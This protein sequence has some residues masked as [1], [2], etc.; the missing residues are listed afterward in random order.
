M[1]ASVSAVSQCQSSGQARVANQSSRES[2]GIRAWILA[3]SLV[4]SV[5][6]SCGLDHHTHTDTRAVVIGSRRNSRIYGRLYSN[7]CA[8]TI[9]LSSKVPC[10][11]SVITQRFIFYF[12]TYWAYL[13]K[14]HLSHH[15]LIDVSHIYSMF[16]SSIHTLALLFF[17]QQR[18]LSVHLTHVLTF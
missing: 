6:H 18:L 8:R 12:S 5:I 10:V 9:T 2:S 7:L 13:W 14:W 15:Y 17:C 3:F 1:L 11:F 4:S 16:D